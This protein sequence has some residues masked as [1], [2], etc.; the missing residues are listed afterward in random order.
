[1]KHMRWAL[2]FAALAMICGASQSR[3][4]QIVLQDT[5]LPNPNG[6]Q[7]DYTVN[8]VFP[9]QVANAAVAPCSNSDTCRTTPDVQ[10]ITVTYTIKNGNYVLQTIAIESPT[11]GFPTG[12]ASL[13]LNTQYTGNTSDLEN[14]NYF[15]HTGNETPGGTTPP[16]AP[17]DGIYSVNSNFTTADGYTVALPG[18]G[19]DG[20]ASGI[21]DSALDLI[22][23]LNGQNDIG[24]GTLGFDAEDYVLVY[25]FTSLG[26]DIILGNTTD[27]GTFSLGGSQYCAND[28][29]LVVGTLPTQ[30]N[31]P[32]VPEPATMML[33]GVGLAGLAGWRRRSAAKTQA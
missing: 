14:W 21:K 15:V 19:R 10:T 22:G 27:G 30:R 31:P 2:A 3:A 33:F 28:Q 16:N 9:S 24:A 23:G 4:D 12:W 13:F 32:S 26:I 1:M 8:Y 6:Q 18:T 5:G 20:V 7:G 25:D 11:A 17:V 29:L